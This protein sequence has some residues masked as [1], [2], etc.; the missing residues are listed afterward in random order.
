[1]K[2]ET[3]DRLFLA[4][5][6]LVVTDIGS[7]PI[8][9][10]LTQVTEIFITRESLAHP[11][12]Y[13]S[14]D[15]HGFRVSFFKWRKK[16]INLSSMNMRN[17]VYFTWMGYYKS[18]NTAIFTSNLSWEREALMTIKLESVQW[19]PPVGF[20]CMAYSMPPRPRIHKKPKL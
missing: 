17:S 4:I 12:D 18:R 14:Y 5:N 13:N 7:M 9:T 15:V 19:A 8:L 20:C 3:V 2:T 10:A 11:G 1:M 16:V 6:W